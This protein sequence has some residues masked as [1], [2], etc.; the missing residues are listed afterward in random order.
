MKHEF[1]DVIDDLERYVAGSDGRQRAATARLRPAPADDSEVPSELNILAALYNL[2][3][4]LASTGLSFDAVLGQLIDMVVN[5]AGAE[6]G[7][8][9]LR[10]TRQYGYS[11]LEQGDL[12]IAAAR[13]GRGNDVRTDWQVPDDVINAVLDDGGP[14]RV[15]SEGASLGMAVPLA[16][17]PPQLA[18][19]IGPEAAQSFREP[20]VRGVLY[21]ETAPPRDFSLEDL[22]FLTTVANHVAA[23]LEVHRL[24]SHTTID[25]VTG[26]FT[27][28]Q[29]SG[30]LET[31]ARQEALYG[32]PF[33]VVF[34]DID[35][36][37]AYNEKHG[38]PDGDRLLAL[39]CK[40]LV[41]H[42][43][44]EDG[45]FRYGA[46]KIVLLLPA[47][48]AEGAE[49]FA[50]T[51]LAGVEDD[52]AEGLSLSLGIAASPEHGT[53][54]QLLLAR[55]DQALFAAKAG[56][57]GAVQVY[58][59]SF[60]ERSPRTD[61]LAGILTGE[62]A[63][64]YKNVL[65]LVDTVSHLGGE[66]E[67]RLLLRTMVDKLIAASGAERGA[68]LL[69]DRG[70]L[71]TAVARQACAQDVEL[72]GQ[73]SRTVAE[74]VFFSGQPICLN[75][76]LEQLDATSSIRELKL[77]TVI[78]VP[79]ASG[80]RTLGVLYLDGPE[81]GQLTEAH[82]PLFTAIA[83]QAGLAVENAR[84]KARLALLGLTEGID[85]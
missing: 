56:G 43:R 77:R 33:A 50:V 5:L 10:S 17:Y 14:V 63:V 6:R 31:L 20:V 18:E 80:E 83:R 62:P 66:P 75:N 73:Y 1:F 71:E 26:L 4:K 28:T 60:G 84:L 19:K 44:R 23:F 74:R 30:H 42:L 2:S 38:A 58:D 67:P 54:P 55:A 61:R 85:S 78:C 57:G 12:R 81:S 34:A 16:L 52:V 27:R 11:S 13:D 79:L 37:R 59:E 47:T 65:A 24:N 3:M 29:L 7:C 15:P 41:S 25:R 72:R 70:A 36:F 8:I 69:A 21:V 46:D 53:D 45:G 51:C 64:D 9:F 48:N 39:I 76:A 35:G 32:V 68:I 40:N 49:N 82:L 22:R